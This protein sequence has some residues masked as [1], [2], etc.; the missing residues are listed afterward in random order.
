LSLLVRGYFPG[1]QKATAAIR[2][3]IESIGLLFAGGQ[4]VE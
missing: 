3:D 4:V 1:N 2:F